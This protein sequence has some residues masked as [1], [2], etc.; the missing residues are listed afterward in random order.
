METWPVMCVPCRRARDPE[1]RCAE[2]SRIQVLPHPWAP[3]PDGGE[4]KESIRRNSVAP[5]GRGLGR[6]LEFF[7]TSRA[8]EWGVVNGA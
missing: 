4:G 3:L 1:G 6:A 5:L 8:V 7:H 2:M